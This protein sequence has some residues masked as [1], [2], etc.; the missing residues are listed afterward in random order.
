[1]SGTARSRG[2]A[3]AISL[4]MSR[5]MALTVVAIVVQLGA[6]FAY[7]HATQTEVLSLWTVLI[8]LI[9][10]TTSV[11]FVAF[12]WRRGP[13]VRRSRLALLAGAGYFLVLA[14]IAGLLFPSHQLLGHHH[15]TA[16]TTVIWTAPGWGPVI[17]YSNTLLQIAVVPFKVIAYVA[18]AY[19][20]AAAV[21]ARSTGTV[22]G[23][24][25]VF[26]CIG[27][28]LPL[29]AVV[30]GVFGSA[31]TVLAMI[32]GS[33]EL[34]TSIFLGTIAILLVVIPTADPVDSV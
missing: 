24:A 30:S 6:T 4:T 17:L 25:G 1:M 10:I 2:V 23:L 33:Y 19:G 27:C 29:L 7:L 5:E 14:L 32:S 21:A 28:L 34:G 11:Y 15:H 20:I 9:W 16:G 26:T 31:S 18:L 22:A 12:L 13:A 8:P 3:R